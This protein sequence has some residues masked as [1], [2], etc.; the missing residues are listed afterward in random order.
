MSPRQ[1]VSH[2]PSLP[3]QMDEINS[4]GKEK[5]QPTTTT[6]MTHLGGIT[7]HL[8]FAKKKNQTIADGNIE[9]QLH[10]HVYINHNAAVRI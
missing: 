4:R 9:Q 3:L 5:H 10:V 8:C 1:P 7:P 6:T 2:Q